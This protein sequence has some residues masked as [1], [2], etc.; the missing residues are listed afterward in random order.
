VKQ[1]ANTLGMIGNLP[2]EF[3]M[4]SEKKSQRYWISVLGFQIKNIFEIERPFK[5]DV[6]QIRREWWQI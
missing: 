5:S 4:M 1:F 2:A 6:K 3:Q